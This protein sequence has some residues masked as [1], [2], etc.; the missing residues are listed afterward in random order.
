MKTFLIQTV[1]GEVVHDF[2]FHLLESI[3]YN[4]WFYNEEIYSYVLSDKIKK[5]CDYIPVGNL[6]FVFEYLKRNHLLESEK[7][8]PL[9]IPNQLMKAC[10]LNREVFISQ[11]DNIS[12]TD[13]RFVKSNSQYK[14]FVDI[15]DNTSSIPNDE[16]IVSE[17]VDIDTEWRAFVQQGDLVGLQHYTGDFTTFPDVSLIKE[18]INTYKDSPLS[19]TLDVG[20]NDKGTF[21]IEVHPFVS[22]GLYGFKDYKKLPIMFIQGFNYLL[23]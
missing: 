5:E 22:C 19:Y 2:T 10:F 13:K 11:K 8:K 15:V 7:I 18:M 21:L 4:N 9:N 14:S 20:V 1:N 17:I 3:R 23:R 6:E 16:Y 12:L